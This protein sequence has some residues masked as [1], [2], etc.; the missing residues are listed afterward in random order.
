MYL[1][2]IGPHFIIAVRNS[3]GS[4]WFEAL[5]YHWLAVFNI[6]IYCMKYGWNL[7]RVE[8]QQKARRLQAGK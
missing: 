7:Q 4:D 8:E 2:M 1:D 5:E 6:I 3:I